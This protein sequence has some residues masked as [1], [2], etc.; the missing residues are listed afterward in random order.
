[1]PN[2]NP[3]DIP[4]QQPD[5]AQEQFA[6]VYTWGQIQEMRND[7]VYPELIPGTVVTGFS[8]LAEMDSSMIL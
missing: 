8:N 3:G 2:Q 5:Q 7:G 1:M 4:P 6:P